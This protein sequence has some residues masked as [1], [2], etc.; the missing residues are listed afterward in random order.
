MACMG[1]LNI[2]KTIFNEYFENDTNLSNLNSWLI[3]EAI[4]ENCISPDVD[5][6][7]LC[8]FAVAQGDPFFNAYGSNLNDDINGFSNIV[9]DV[10]GVSSAYTI[11]EFDDDNANH[12]I[13]HIPNAL[14]N[15]IKDDHKDDIIK[16]FNIYQFYDYLVDNPEKIYED[17]L[18]FN[19]YDFFDVSTA[20]D[21]TFSNITKYKTQN[22][23]EKIITA[24][25]SKD[26][27]TPSVIYMC[28]GLY[29]TLLYKH[30]AQI[31]LSYYTKCD[32][33][34]SGSDATCPANAITSINDLMYNFKTSINKLILFST[35]ELEVTYY[36]DTLTLDNPGTSA[37]TF[38]TTLN[39]NNHIIH[40]I[41][42]NNFI[43][44]DSNP[45]TLTNNSYTITHPNLA[46]GDKCV[47]LAKKSLYAAYSYNTTIKGLNNNNREFDSN[48][49]DYQKSITNYEI[50]NGSFS[51]IDYI[52]YL[53][54]LI[55]I[56]VLVSIGATNSEQSRKTRVL[57]ILIIVVLTYVM[58]FSYLEITKR[59]AESFTAASD[60]KTNEI[61]IINEILKNTLTNLYI[62]ASNYGM[63]RLYDKLNAA[64]KNEL[65]NV[66]KQNTTLS[67]SIDRTDATTNSEWHRLFQ[68]TL[69]IH[70]VFMFLIVILIYLWLSTSIPNSSI[71]LLFITI[72]A[73]MVLIFNYFRN[74][75][76]VVRSEYKHR[77]WTKMDV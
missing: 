50:V 10:S 25:N 31:Y 61:G 55:V 75:H 21:I 1:L 33:L 5:V 71:Y 65:H 48:K 36:N 32:A 30:I 47:I 20:T 15:N 40:N 46:N 72:I 9:K 43:E 6:D 53:T 63:T 59:L 54:F 24:N 64:A 52:Y 29:L 27:L 38:F 68:R 13:P 44:I 41:T 39:T 73:L 37:G 45:I 16:I 8:N 14:I 69:F 7:V 2:N 35:Y 22:H 4:T 34:K 19:L 17:N 42:K 70:T 3:D 76:R 62:S 18:G 51:N 57:I 26:K 66:S 77:Y 11:K 23:Y 56:I 67:S 60:K 49:A 28:R 12:F 58:I 74:L